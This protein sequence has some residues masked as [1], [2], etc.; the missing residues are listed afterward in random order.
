MFPHTF[1]YHCDSLSHW[2][3]RLFDI[4]RADSPDS[5]L[6]SLQNGRVYVTWISGPDSDDDETPVIVK[7]WRSITTALK[8]QQN[9]CRHNSGH[10]SLVGSSGSISAVKTRC[11]VIAVHAR[12]L[13]SISTDI[14]FNLL[15]SHSR[16][17][18][19]NSEN[20]CQTTLDMK[21]VVH[22]SCV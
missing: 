8:V 13:R 7:I 2:R 21:C 17:L 3:C 18:V 9:Y 16:P 5:L 19:K 6:F 4:Y 14:G 20:L 22:G 12:H 11:F 1:R 10:S 15:I